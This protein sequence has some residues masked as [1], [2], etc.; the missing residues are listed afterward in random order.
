M[1]RRSREERTGAE[2]EMKEAA[3]C[4]EEQKQLVADAL[5]ESAG[6]SFSLKE[7]PAASCAG[8]VPALGGWHC[9]RPQRPTRWHQSGRLGRSRGRA[10]K[11]G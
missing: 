6:E 8:V 7:C 5:A 1:M 2:G 11:T 9:R 3:G 4:D 10:T